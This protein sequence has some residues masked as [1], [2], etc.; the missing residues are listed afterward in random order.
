MLTAFI[1]YHIAR[2][3]DVKRTLAGNSINVSDNNDPISQTKAKL[4]QPFNQGIDS[5]N[6]IQ[7]YICENKEDYPE[8]NG[9]HRVKIG[10][11]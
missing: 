4:Y 9:E 10:W 11:L 3:L 5:F 8:F 6:A 7:F 2:E 1:F